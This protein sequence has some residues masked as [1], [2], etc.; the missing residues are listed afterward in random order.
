MASKEASQKENE[1]FLYRQI[2]K[3]HD[4]VQLFSDLDEAIAKA[5]LFVGEHNDI[6]GCS[7][8]REESNFGGVYRT[9]RSNSFGQRRATVRPVYADKP[10]GLD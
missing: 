3:G 8:R 6:D 4:M 5:K 9:Y 1:M 7:T 2:A 10:V